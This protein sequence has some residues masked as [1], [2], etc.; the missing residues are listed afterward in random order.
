[1][2]GGCEGAIRRIGIFAW[3]EARLL[4]PK[5]REAPVWPPPPFVPFAAAIIA[6]R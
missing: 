5:W 2:A 3:R 1:M 6:I 4:P